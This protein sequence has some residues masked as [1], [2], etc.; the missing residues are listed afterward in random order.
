MP[1]I[2]GMKAPTT[3]APK[4]NKR[5]L[6]HGL[7]TYRRLLEGGKLDGRTSLHKVL[8]EKERE[9]V[10]ALG[11]DP[12]P[13]EQILITD[14][15]KTLLYVATLDEYLMSLDGGIVRNGKVISVVDTRVKL[16]AHLK[17]TLRTIGLQRKTKQ[18]TL[19]DIL[20]ESEPEVEAQG[21]SDEEQK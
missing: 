16:A 17:E 21:N 19:A 20:R 14:A 15:V 13:Q 6:K 4:G 1:F 5:A 12:S 9:L 8:R 11:G 18:V 7:H 2:K 3:P 10:T